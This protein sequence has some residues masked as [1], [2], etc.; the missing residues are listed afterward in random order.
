L[1]ALPSRWYRDQHA[2][3]LRR[4][5]MRTTMRASHSSMWTEAARALSRGAVLLV[6]V[7]CVCDDAAARHASP[8]LGLCLETPAVTGVHGEP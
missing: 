4:L 6:L 2:S 8:Q 5:A 3:E 1:G 7:L